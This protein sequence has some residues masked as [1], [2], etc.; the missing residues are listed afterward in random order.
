MQVFTSKKSLDLCS[1]MPITQDFLDALRAS[2]PAPPVAV[3]DLNSLLLGVSTIVAAF[4]I[5]LPLWVVCAI[6]VVGIAIC[7]KAEW[8][9]RMKS[10]EK[11]VPQM[12]MFPYV[13]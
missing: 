4:M 13:K 6:C 1:E 10:K 9:Y 2:F 11:T 7:I 3:R 8:T 5:E 12:P